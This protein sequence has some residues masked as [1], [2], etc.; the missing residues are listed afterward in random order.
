MVFT[1]LVEIWCYIPFNMTFIYFT[2]TNNIQKNIFDFF[3][4]V[5][6]FFLSIITVSAK[7]A[8]CSF[9][10]FSFFSP[11][12][13][14]QFC[15]AF[16]IFSNYYRKKYLYW[17]NVLSA[18][19]FTCVCIFWIWIYRVCVHASVWILQ[20]FCTSLNCAC[21]HLCLHSSLCPSFFL[22][23][24][25]SPSATPTLLFVAVVTGQPWLLH[26]RPNPSPR[27]SAFWRAH[28]KSGA[29]TP[30][31]GKSLKKNTLMEDLAE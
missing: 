30:S 17:F 29:C 2:L 14:L 22:F 27:P 28:P 31:S 26:T 12:L 24:A 5:M 25:L 1:L 15:F 23:L 11:K 20:D 19:K 18:C 10:W 7:T 9:L 6:F 21:L 4:V 13:L 8:L 16:Q 3:L